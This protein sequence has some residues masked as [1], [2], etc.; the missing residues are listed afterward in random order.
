[1]ISRFPLVVLA[2]VCGIVRCEAA[3][4]SFNGVELGQRWDAFLK[5][6]PGAEVFWPSDDEMS[7]SKAQ[8]LVKAGKRKSE[9]LLETRTNKLL[10]FG[11]YFFENRILKQSTLLNDLNGHDGRVFVPRSF[12]ALR[13][14]L[15][16]VLAELGAPTAQGVTKPNAHGGDWRQ[17]LLV[18]KKPTQCIFVVATWPKDKEHVP[19]T[20]EF[21]LVDAPWRA[22]NGGFITLWPTILAPNQDDEARRRQL[23]ALLEELHPHSTD[24]IEVLKPASALAVGFKMDDIA[25]HKSRSPSVIIKKAK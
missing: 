19:T 23:M 11:T 13:P 25:P 8:R 14:S 17:T 3:P 18:W 10:S 16:S 6:H 2:L 4:L 24:R 9:M 20:V 5:A 12:E 1:M 22:T 7:L 15:Q 21:H